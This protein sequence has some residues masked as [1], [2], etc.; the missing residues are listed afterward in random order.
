[1]T[2]LKNETSLHVSMVEPEEEVRP[3]QTPELNV[4]IQIDILDIVFRHVSKSLKNLMI[5]EP[6]LKSIIL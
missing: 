3:T 1:M 2:E 6:L 4:P 5:P